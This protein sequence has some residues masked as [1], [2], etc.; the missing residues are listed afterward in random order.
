MKPLMRLVGLVV[1]LVGLAFGLGFVLPSTVHVEREITINTPPET[2]FALV[3]DFRQWDAWS[4]WAS[5]D[6]DA[7]L[8]IT[9][10]GI[11]QTMTWSSDNPQVGSG[12]QEVVELERPIYL[13]TH[14]TFAGQGESD[15]AFTLIPDHDVTRVRWSLDTDSREG[16][17]LW[18]QPIATYF[19][20]A[21]DSMLGSTYETGLQNLKALAEHQA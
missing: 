9:G 21:L 2:I 4:P 17:P 7:S 1:G 13:K 20:F 15:A 16:V 11:G 8:T 19:G 12:T 6:P 18:Q 14:L 5:L 10:S 3:S